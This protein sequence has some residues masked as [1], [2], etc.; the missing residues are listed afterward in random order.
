MA[1]NLLFRIASDLEAKGFNDAAAAVRKIDKDQKAAGQQAEGHKKK[2]DALKGAY[3]ALLGLGIVAFFK[4]AV[5]EAVT[6][7]LLADEPGDLS[8]HVPPLASLLT[9][10]IVKPSPE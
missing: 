1:D 5:D 6:S 7:W 4:S 2:V 10:G 8:R 9:S 3:A